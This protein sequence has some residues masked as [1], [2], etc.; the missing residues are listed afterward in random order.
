MRNIYIKILINSTLRSE[1]RLIFSHDDIQYSGPNHVT[2]CSHTVGGAA[3][4]RPHAR[5]PV[6]HQSSHKYNFVAHV[7]FA[8]LYFTHLSLVS[9]KGLVNTRTNKYN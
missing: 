9:V 2:S 6:S 3:G 4:E 8:F 5:K 7:A 1:A